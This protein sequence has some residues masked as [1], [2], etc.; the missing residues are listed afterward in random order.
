MRL[1]SVV[2]HSHDALDKFVILNVANADVV[3]PLNDAQ[4]SLVA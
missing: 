2:A 3:L 1:P 4:Y